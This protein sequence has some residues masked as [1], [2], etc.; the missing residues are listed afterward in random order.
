[1]AQDLIEFPQ[2]CFG[3]VFFSRGRGRGHVI[4][5]VSLMD[6]VCELLPNVSIRW[7]SYSTG[8]ETLRKLG[9]DVYDLQFSDDNPFLATQSQA[10]S[11]MSKLK[12]RLVI[13]HE[14]FAAMPAA[15]LLGLPTLFV[16]DYFLRPN[17]LWMECLRYADE[18]IYIDDPGYFEAPSFLQKKIFYTGK[19][20]RGFAYTAQDR[21][22]ARR[23]L[24]LQPDSLLVVV[25]SG[26]R[27]EA[28]APIFNLIIPAYLS[29]PG[30]NKRLLW[31]AGNDTSQIAARLKRFSDI[32]VTD[33][34]RHIDRWIAACDLAIT[35]ATRKISL[36][37]ASF[38]KPTISISH[39]VNF[40][41][42]IR[43]KQ[44]S[45]NV[46]L[47]ATEIN[48]DILTDH[49]KRLLFRSSHFR[50]AESKTSGLA[51]GARRIARHISQL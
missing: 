32:T 2:G 28:E 18:I 49:I 22:V 25:F 5:D 40:V 21:E 48:S 39:Q 50:V 29:L 47:L 19:F 8:A 6:A 30:A 24:S 31:I 44:I 16:I 11:I 3:I 15:K 41:D 35:K 27:P 33:F 13:A 20:I 17:H 7:I 45:T 38:G 12:P 43:V 46:H 10:I 51:N 37:L 14:E 26:D 4:P 34:D 9:R 36:E 23:E 42:D 1:M